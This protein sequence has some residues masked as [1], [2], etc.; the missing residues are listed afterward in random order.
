MKIKMYEE[1]DKAYQISNAFSEEL[2]ELMGKYIDT[3]RDN[4]IEPETCS[5]FL[6]N[7]LIMK[8]FEIIEYFQAEH[9][10]ELY[11]QF[12]EMITVRHDIYIKERNN[13]H[14]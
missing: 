11:K 13:E 6:T 2:H 14:L 1:N 5:S 10:E 7:V 4:N 9:F 3:F 12:L 8:C